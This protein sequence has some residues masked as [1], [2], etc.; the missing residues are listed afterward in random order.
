MIRNLP[1]NFKGLIEKLNDTYAKSDKNRSTLDKLEWENDSG[2]SILG[3]V[4]VWSNEVVGTVSKINDSDKSLV[5]KELDS[6]SINKK[7]DILKWVTEFEGKYGAFTDYIK[8]N[9]VQ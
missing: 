4:E 7:M 6:L 8:A 3:L 1:E 9:A 2:V 5:S